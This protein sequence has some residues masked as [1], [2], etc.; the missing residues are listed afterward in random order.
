MPKNRFK[1]LI[2]QKSAF[3]QFG[4]EFTKK[5]SELLPECEI[6]VPVSWSESE[7]LGLAEDADVIFGYDVSKKI[8]GATERLK[9]IQTSGTGVDK[10][11]MDTATEKGVL[12]C[13]S[14]GLNAVRVAE[15]AIALILALAKK[16]TRFDSEIKKG[17]WT[18][19]ATVKLQDK[20]LG[21]VG[22]GSIGIEVAKRMK[23]FGM[24]ILA[25]KRNPSEVLR[26]KYDLAFLGGPT[27]LDHLLTQSDFLVLSAVL[28]PETRRMIG[29]RELGM[30]KET[31][32]LVNVSR[33]EVIDEGAL[34]EALKEGKIAG[35]GL[36]VLQKEP[37][38]PDNLLLKMENVVL[39]PHVGGGRSFEARLERIEFMTDNTRRIMRG[40]RPLNIVDP[41]LK[42]VIERASPP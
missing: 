32:F 41:K 38:N 24:K 16:V 33:G 14:V 5:I 30:M 8:I 39:T 26:K 18:P 13:N 2:L 3:Q 7:I 6:V 25:I 36:D 28:T 35:A 22:L 34:I 17:K 4:S 12:V 23:P 1:I 19:S 37:T 27:D 10:V 20:I 40:E 31:T 21:I 11:D 9:L 42:Y 15:H 29:R